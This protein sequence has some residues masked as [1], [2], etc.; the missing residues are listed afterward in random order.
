MN[1]FNPQIFK[2]EFEFEF[3]YKT[4]VIL[5]GKGANSLEWQVNKK[6]ELHNFISNLSTLLK[7]GSIGFPK[8][9]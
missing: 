3:I 9:K 1:N 5:A 7:P 8:L 6:E 4:C 2:F